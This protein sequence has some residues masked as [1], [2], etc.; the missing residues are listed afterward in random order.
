MIISKKR[1]SSKYQY[2]AEFKNID[3]SEVLSDD[4]QALDP[5]QPR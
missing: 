2:K 3:D 1:K 5:L 4:F